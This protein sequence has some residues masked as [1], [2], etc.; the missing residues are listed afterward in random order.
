MSIDDDISIKLAKYI[1]SD[2]NVKPKDDEF[3]RAVA[4][5]ISTTDITEDQAKAMADKI[6]GGESKTHERK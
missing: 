4:S 6:F 1:R 3:D 2:L 5:E